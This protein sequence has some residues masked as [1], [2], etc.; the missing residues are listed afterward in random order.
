MIRSPSSLLAVSLLG[1]FVIGPGAKSLVAD[2]EFSVPWRVESN[3]Q[4]GTGLALYWFPKSQ[5]EIDH[6]PLRHSRAL[7][8]YAQQCV[9][10]IIADYRGPIG[11]RYLGKQISR[12]PSVV[13][14]DT[15]G[16]VLG[17][18]KPKDGALDPIEVER[19]L[20]SELERRGARLDV[21]LHDAGRKIR[22]GDK[23]AARLLL[24]DVLKQACIFPAK[25]REAAR[26]RKGLEFAN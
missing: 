23:A 11:G 13:L 12:V 17:R 26:L 1:A 6:S 7:S 10:L 14:A 20:G 24:D 25:A 15:D 9:Y 18:V 5:D 3:L 16:M 21:L 22:S 4:T 8:I 2:E 19:L